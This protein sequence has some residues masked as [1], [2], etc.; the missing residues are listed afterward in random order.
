[1]E[2]TKNKDAQIVGALMMILALATLAMQTMGCA[3]STGTM[4]PQVAHA[5][6]K[7]HNHAA[8]APKPWK[9]SKRCK[10]LGKAKTSHVAVLV[11][12]NCLRNGLTT[13]NMVVLNKERE[14]KVAADHAA[15]ATIAILGF[16]PTLTLLFMG[17][18]KGKVFYLTAV[19][20]STGPVAVKGN[21]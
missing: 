17:K 21:P 13:V 2:H 4:H 6:H 11:E 15:Q 20:E 1:M 18:L 5:E 10:T 9:K 14:G 19:G 8:P 3:A 16:K 7:G 12:R